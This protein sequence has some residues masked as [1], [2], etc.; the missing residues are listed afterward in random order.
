WQRLFRRLFGALITPEQT[1]RLRSLGGL[2]ETL[3]EKRLP[4]VTRLLD[5]LTEVHLL[6]AEQVGGTTWYEFRHDYL[7]PRI[8][9]WLQDYE[10]TLSGRR[11]R[12]ALIP[13]IV[14]A[15]GLLAPGVA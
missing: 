10:V 6:R 12:N 1:R 2:A 13:G 11:V 15:A 14:L 3:G 5:R 8:V 9:E 4:V 7:V